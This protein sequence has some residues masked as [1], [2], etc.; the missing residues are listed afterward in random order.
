MSPPTLLALLCAS[1]VSPV[2]AAGAGFT[3][4]TGVATLAFLSSVGSGVLSAM[5]DRVL[6]RL[7]TSDGRDPPAADVTE[8]IARSLEEALAGDDATARDL[9]ADIAVL[10]GEINV[11]EVGWQ[12]ETGSTEGA[13]IAAFRGLSE[14]Y[15]R[16]DGVAQDTGVI[17]HTTGLIAWNQAEQGEMLAEILALSRAGLAGVAAE[18]HPRPRWVHGC[19]YRGLEPFAEANSRV[20]YGRELMT[21]ELVDKV[22]RGGLTVVIGPSGAGKSSLLQAGL[23]PALA[24]GVRVPGSEHWPRLVITPADDPLGKLAT[25]LAGLGD[26][27]R[28]RIRDE[29]A[30]E[31]DKAQLTVRQALIGHH[32]RR[33]RPQAQGDAM[34]LVLVVDQFEQVFTLNQGPDAE[35]RRRSFIAALR[36]AVCPSDPP[37]AGPAALV[38]LAVRSDYFDACQ[39]CPGLGD[40]LKEELFLV[41]PMNRSEFAMAITGP[42]AEAGLRT[43]PG[44]AEAI[45]SDVYA[46]RPNDATAAL[47]LLSQA[48]RL[49]WEHREGNR[50]TVHGYDQTG[51]VSRAVQTSAEMAYDSLPA[52]ERALT[53]EI[54]LQLTVISD[55]RLGRRPVTRADLYAAHPA[56]DQPRLDAILEAFAARRLIVLGQGIVQ[57]AHDAL[58]TGWPRLGGWLGEDMA[59]MALLSQLADDST[60][61]LAH[62]RNDAFLYRGIRLAAVQQSKT[63]WSAR[64]DRYPLTPDQR[65][66]L[67]TSQRVATRRA[68]QLRSLAAGLVI[69][70]I[71]S[72]AG[73]LYA[74]FAD[75]NAN[76]QRNIAVSAQLATLSEAQD[77][78]DPVT[79]A[80][81][82]A[83]AWQ[84]KHT[85]KAR[86][87][88]L[89]VLTQ[90]GRAALTRGGPDRAVAF[91]PR[92]SGILAT[93][94]RAI[95]LWNLATN[96][97]IGPPMAVAGD[98]NAVTFNRAGTILATADGDGTARLWDVATHRQIGP[99]MLASSSNGV[100][101]VTFNRAGTIL[102]TADGDGTARL[103]DVATHRQIGPTLSDGGPATSGAQ[104]S[105]VAFSPDGKVLATSSLD[106]TVRLWDVATGRQIGAAMTDGEHL[107]FL[108]QMFAITFSPD[109]KILATADGDGTA[110]LW[111]V[112]THRQIGPAITATEGASDVAFSPDG[113]L[114][115]VAEGDGLA[116]LWDVATRDPVNPPVSTTAAGAMSEAAFSPDGS[117]LAT[118]SK[119]GA[120]RLWSLGIFRNLEPATNA[121]DMS[122]VA[123][124]PDG[125]IMAAVDFE[126]TARLWNLTTQR[127]I[128]RPIRAST[129][130]GVLAVA[131]SLDGNTL[132]TGD[133][134]GTVRLWNLA[135]R[136]QIGPPITASRSGSV[137]AVSFSPD[138]KTL[139]AGDDDGTARL[140]NTTT[141]R[142]TGPAMSTGASQ[143]TVLAFSPDGTT[144]AIADRKGNARLWGLA[145]GRPLGVAITASV[146]GMAFSPD[147][148]T[149]A[150]ADKDGTARFWSLAAGQQIGTPVV[151]TSL[152]G[153]TWVAFS[154]DGTLLAT[155]G[156]NGYAGIWD[157]ATHAEV[158]PALA[159][160]GAG[161]GLA[162]VAFTS[163]GTALATVGGGGTATLWDVAFPHDLLGA[164]CSIAG[165]S[166]TRQ[167]W[168]TLVPSEPYLRACP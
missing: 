33:G 5:L 54:L 76:D 42:A 79:A 93:A 13:L 104:V 50:L 66:F 146:A 65:A 107:S 62:D 57:I 83:A 114:I 130:G 164:M 36:A 17:R 167:E 38:V 137:S 118:V 18:G 6:D 24:D 94:G 30:H 89:E 124:S 64:Q 84:V 138:G 45:I 29:L 144:L 82:A 49:T 12:G 86:E 143:L 9:W 113:K 151:A 109:G 4:A 149:L 73:A 105:S 160:S 35:D 125:K 39:K 153:A 95:Q 159:A 14:V 136:H 97:P 120:T 131:F 108:K 96:H 163:D 26:G 58:L 78:A 72:C 103:W 63:R 110:R 59:S 40:T 74:A 27:D 7:K 148:K 92:H 158:G 31:P 19:P 85:D 140:W 147:G 75:K 123:F 161:L 142:A 99:T 133:D 135:T 162:A 119:D 128:G 3:E 28:N 154:P 16:L 61:W 10:L 134:D 23:L 111:D 25:A 8:E 115:A 166:L 60:T 102:A 98:A 156:A 51:G 48:M 101:V 22:A 55:G 67:E 127:Q 106:G 145:V 117:M 37:G 168:S 32:L 21:G 157:V 141:R 122:A 68:R 81:L 88:M 91:G 152:D 43:E 56:A 129:A 80:R 41:G 1:S 139:A 100:N 77:I 47:P 126:G 121:G 52:E 132:A 44:L 70:L 112:A 90:P 53:R 46:M 87:S 2:I 116:R 150:T 165:R 11:P 155:A 20:F 69:L 34:R 71:A 15:R